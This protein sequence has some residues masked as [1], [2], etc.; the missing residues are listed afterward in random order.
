MLNWEL[1][2]IKITEKLGGLFLNVKIDALQ[3]LYKKGQ[4]KRIEF[5]HEEQELAG[6]LLSSILF[7][8]CKE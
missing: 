7:H 4:M 8:I 3:K 2:R 6:H 5:W 1:E